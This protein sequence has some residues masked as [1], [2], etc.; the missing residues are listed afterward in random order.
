M[1]L[2]AEFFWKYVGRLMFTSV[3]LLSACSLMTRDDIKKEDENKQ[4]RDQVSSIEKSKADNEAHYNDLENDL[5]AMSGRVDTL[6]H[7]EQMDAKNQDKVLDDLKKV[8]DAQNDKIK[9]LEQHI[10]ATETRLTAAIQAM[11]TAPAP[12]PEPKSE[13]KEGKSKD[14]GLYGEAENLFNQKD[15]KHA[16]IKYQAYRDKN[17]KGS[18]LAE[19]T[20]KIAVCFSELGQKKDAKDFY[21]ETID[22]YPGTS[23]AKKAKLRLSQNK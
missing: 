3:L 13:A 15:F 21:Q 5:R 19:A 17:P 12:Q 9:M 22:S 6:D 8:I 10:D 14:G 16:I 18:K 7:N 23:A 11:A 20:Y 1:R 2:I 4:L